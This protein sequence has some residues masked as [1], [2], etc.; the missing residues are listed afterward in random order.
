MSLRR[1][2]G[3]RPAAER[4]GRSAAGPGEGT[5]PFAA[6]DWAILAAIVAI[7]MLF[8]YGATGGS[9]AVFYDTFRDMAYAE[10]IRAG[11]LWADPTILGQAYWYAPGSPALVALLMALTGKTALQLYGTS[12]FWLNW[13]NPVLLFLLVRRSWGRSAALVAL[14]MV[15]LG[16]YWWLT[17]AAAPMPSV[18]GLALDFAGL[19]TWRRA[20][21]GG[22]KWPA[23]TGLVVALAAWHHPLSAVVLAGAIALHALI[24]AAAPSAPSLASNFRGHP[25]LAPLARA[26]IAAATAAVLSSPLILHLLAGEK[27]NLAPYTWFGPELHDPRFALQAL[28]PLVPFLGFLGAALALKVPRGDAWL[29]AYLAVGLV[30]QGAGYL[31]HDLGWEVPFLIP[32]EFQWH[33]QLALGIGAAIAIVWLGR[34]AARRVAAMGLKRLAFGATMVALCAAGVGPALPHLP[35]A[36]SY[37]RRIDA[38]WG[39]MLDVGRWVRSSTG[40]DAT[41]A[42]EENLCYYLAGLTGR[43]CVAVLAGHMNPRLDAVRRR[44][45]LH[46]MLGATREPVFA[47]L[48]RQ[49]QVNYLLVPLDPEG[50][51]KVLETYPSWRSIEPAFRE[52]GFAEVFR[53]RRDE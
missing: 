4:T 36:G 28:T 13:L 15:G 44:A 2:R 7:W 3:T 32:H 37:L 30:G 1:E 17:H 26:G 8:A 50:Q 49:Y 47:A 27:R 48:A 23:I 33:A 45:D 39:P 24:L 19:M 12:M 21:D 43:K 20:L 53:I 16:S 52:E 5:R 18:Q 14:P 42:C 34:A 22:Y 10:N 29:P 6:A 25:R 51:R 41:F 40:I 35:A 46:E 11:R 31:A 38:S 9:L